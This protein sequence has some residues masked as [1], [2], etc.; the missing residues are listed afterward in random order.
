MK[1]HSITL[2]WIGVCLGLTKLA[3]SQACCGNP[4][5]SGN[6]ENILSF[7]TLSKKGLVIDLNTDFTQLK[8][9]SHTNNPHSHGHNHSHGVHHHHNTN[10]IDTH[11]QLQSIL[12]STLQIRY[13]L[14]EKLTLH[15]QA[16]FWIANSSNRH[17]S[18]LGD[19]SVSASYRIAQSEKHG[20]GTTIGLELPTGNTYILFENNYL[21]TGSGSIDPFIAAFLWFKHSRWL[22]RTQ[23]YYKQGMKGFDN[24]HFGSTFNTQTWIAYY[25]TN[26]DRKDFAVNLNTGLNQDWSEPHALNRQWIENTG[27]FVL[28]YHVGMQVRYKKFILPAHF[29]IPIYT[30]LRGIQNQPKWR[31]KTGLTWLLY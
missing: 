17:A 29:L 30:D 6:T 2:I 3:K 16:P 27:S 22:A 10:S 8:H 23:S 19:V 1:K 13:G 20:I 7:T 28:W 12:L 4:N 14:H 18:L 9:N 11:A 15:A 5:I 25:L 24:I 31:I 21:I 26:L